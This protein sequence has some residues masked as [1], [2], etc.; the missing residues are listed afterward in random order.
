[1]YLQVQNMES[2]LHTLKTDL[3]TTDNK[4]EAMRNRQ[5][6]RQIDRQIDRGVDRQIE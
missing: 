4:L 1:M 2:E 6:N 3:I 5:I